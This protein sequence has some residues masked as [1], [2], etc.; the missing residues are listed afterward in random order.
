MIDEP[1]LRSVAELTG[2]AFY[3]A[4]DADQ[5]RGVFARLPNQIT[6][7]KEDREITVAFAILGALLAAAAIVLTLLWNRTP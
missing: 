1:T 4:Q 5:L 6:L 3:R 2:G 7:Q